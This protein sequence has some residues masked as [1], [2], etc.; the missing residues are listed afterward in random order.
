MN[1]AFIY[2]GQGSQYVGMGKD[3]YVRFSEVQEIYGK[4]NEILGFDLADVSF[5]GPEEKLKQTYITQPAIFLHSWAMTNLVGKKLEAGYTAGHSLGE[6]TALVY[7]GALSFED[8]LKLVKLRGELMQKA[9]EMQKGTMAA[10]IGLDSKKLEDICNTASRSGI[11]QV[12]NFNSPGQIVISGSVEGVR[13]AMDLAKENKAKMVKELIVHGAFHSPLMEPAREELKI[14]LDNTE[15][16]NIRIPVY[17]N[18]SSKAISPSTPPSKIRELSYRQLTSPVRWEESI[19][20]MIN[21]GANEFIELG[22]G[23][24]LQGLTKRINSTIKTRG[25][26]KV[27]DLNS[28]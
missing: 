15:Y 10:V 22:P 24:V 26:D 7:A 4:A 2:P 3:L 23:K 19:V 18:V 25:F 11:V 16:H 1:T 20:N 12:A 21:D 17:P 8:G 9:G 13:K 14:A 28:L 27:E 6:F 5:N